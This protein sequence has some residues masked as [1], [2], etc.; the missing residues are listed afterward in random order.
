MGRVSGVLDAMGFHMG[1]EQ[2]KQILLLDREFE[3]LK[4]QVT[5][6]QAEN[7]NLRAQMSPLQRELDR[8]KNA[9]NQNAAGNPDGY[10]C[11]H[12]GSPKLKRTGN[13]PNPTFRDLGVKDA[14]FECLDCGKESTFIQEPRR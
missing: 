8:L 12:C 6:L 10:V 2:R 5:A 1:Q 11:D 7:Q 14:L 9:V 3:E 13:R 4:A